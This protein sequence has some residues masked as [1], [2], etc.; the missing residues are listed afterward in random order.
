[1][2]DCLVFQNNKKLALVE[3]KSKFYD[4]STVREKFSNSGMKGI[5]IL[6]SLDSNDFKIY[7][8]L[9]AKSYKD[10]SAYERIR[11]SK[12]KLGNQK[13]SYLFR[14]CLIFAVNVMLSGTIEYKHLNRYKYSIITARCGCSLD[15][16]TQVLQLCKNCRQSGCH[17]M[18][19][20]LSY[21]W[22]GHLQYRLKPNC[23]RLSPL[24]LQYGLLHN[25]YS[26]REGV[27]HTYTQ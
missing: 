19:T 23:T 10:H 15:K 17:V 12:V 6:K 16:L 25:S 20:D 14:S 1:M 5:S 18:T 27:T 4:V 8:I 2:C 11:R 24:R 3:L 13:Y 21:G 9:L 7:M 26:V 22:H